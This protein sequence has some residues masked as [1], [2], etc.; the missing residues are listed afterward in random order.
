MERGRSTGFGEK[1]QTQGLVAFGRRA[2]P[3]P[4]TELGKPALHINKIPPKTMT[5]IPKPPPSKL[6]PNDHRVITNKQKES[7]PHSLEKKNTLTPPTHIKPKFVNHPPLPL[8]QHTL[9][10]KKGL[11]TEKPSQRITKAGDPF[12]KASKNS[13]S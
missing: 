5:S 1:K 8:G 3:S 2:G 9:T 4:K 11:F 10:E 6:D 7:I 13:F 12:S